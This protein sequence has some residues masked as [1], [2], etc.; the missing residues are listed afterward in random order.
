M[1]PVYC[2]RALWGA[3]APPRWQR[4]FV[5]RDRG[6]FRTSSPPLPN[7]RETV[8]FTRTSL[9]PGYLD[10]LAISERTTVKLDFDKPTTKREEW[11]HAL[12]QERDGRCMFHSSS[13]VKDERDRMAVE[14]EAMHIIPHAKGDAYIEAFELAHQVPD[15]DKL[16]GTNDPRNGLFVNLLS[17]TSAFSCCCAQVPNRYINLEDVDRTHG[18]PD[19]RPAPLPILVEDIL[20][21]KLQQFALG[22]EEDDE[23]TAADDSD[24]VNTPQLLSDRLAQQRAGYEAQESAKDV[25]KLTAKGERAKTEAAA[26]KAYEA[27]GYSTFDPSQDPESLMNDD[28]CLLLHWLNEVRPTWKTNLPN[29]IQAT[30]RRGTHLSRHALHASYMCHRTPM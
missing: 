15:E 10:L 11:F 14:S 17:S 20:K 19:E 23:F 25:A 8:S 12:V 4:T 24:G 7:F 2:V 30:L 27:R 13:P 16:Q 22:L 3:R 9:P 1:V 28:S 21:M 5:G 18:I 29:N 26:A 6:P